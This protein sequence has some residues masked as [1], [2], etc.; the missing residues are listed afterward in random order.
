MASVQKNILIVEDEAP[1]INILAEK[2]EDEGFSAIK[3]RNGEEGLRLALSKSVDLIL[4]D[5][6]MPVMDGMTMLQ[7]LREDEKSK[8]IPVILLTNLNTIENISIALEEGAYDYLVKT[9]W[10]L[11]DVVDQVKKKLK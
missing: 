2:L 4:L 10:S 8:E 1:L 6:I 5:I 7:K 11:D 3:A 9:D